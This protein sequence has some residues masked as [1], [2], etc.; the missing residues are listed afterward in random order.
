KHYTCQPICSDAQLWRN[1]GDE[2]YI[3]VV[4]A[5]IGFI[6]IIL[7]NGVVIYV[8]MIHKSLQEPMYIFISAL[9]VNGLYGSISFFPSLLVNLL[10]KTQ[11]ISYINCL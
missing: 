3:Y 11:A 5:L 6:M 2:I 4:I 1:D 8:I 10:A 7:S 9:C